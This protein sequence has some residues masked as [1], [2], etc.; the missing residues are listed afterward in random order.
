MSAAQSTISAGSRRGLL[1]VLRFG[2][3][4]EPAAESGLVPRVVEAEE[5][6]GAVALG[7]AGYASLVARVADG[8]RGSGIST[9]TVVRAGQTPARSLGLPSAGGA[10]TCSTAAVWGLSEKRWGRRCSPALYPV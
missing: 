6:G 7:V 2:E 3:E 5:I 9:R 8:G 1:E 4:G 10:V